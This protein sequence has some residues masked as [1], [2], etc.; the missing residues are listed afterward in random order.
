[1]MLTVQIQRNWRGYYVRKY[2]FD[3]RAYKE[4]LKG[5]MAINEITRAWIREESERIQ[6]E[7]LARETQ[8]QEVWGCGLTRHSKR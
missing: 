4:Y 1:M 5:V 8:M 3:Y 7:K 6:Q 2:V